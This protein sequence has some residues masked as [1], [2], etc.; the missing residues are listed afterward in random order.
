MAEC[1]RACTRPHTRVPT[2]EIR[3][4]FPFPL[5]QLLPPNPLAV[6]PVSD[7]DPTGGLLWRVRRELPF[8]DDAFKVVLARQ[9]EQALAVA[10]DVVAIEKAFA[11]SGHQ[12]AEPESA[13]AKGQ[14]PNILTVA[15][16]TLFLSIIRRRMFV[17]Q[18]VE[19]VKDWL[20]TS[21]QQV[22]EL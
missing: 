5:E 3:I 9:L 2:Q 22:A 1:R 7:F 21:E 17:P 20:S 15:E 18:Y 12:L 19:G 10:F 14:V 13:V 11:A 16:S 6:I 8:G 4:P